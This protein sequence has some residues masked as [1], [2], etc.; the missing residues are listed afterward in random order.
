VQGIAQALGFTSAGLVLVAR[1]DV[2]NLTTA[3]N[4]WMAVAVGVG[5]GA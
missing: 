3:V 2:R 4:L 5:A 1:G